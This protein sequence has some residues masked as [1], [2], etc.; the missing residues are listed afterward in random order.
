MRPQATDA[1]ADFDGFGGEAAP[2]I[3]QAD[4]QRTSGHQPEPRAEAQIEAPAQPEPAPAAADEEPRRRQGRTTPFDGS[5]K[6]EL[7]VEQPE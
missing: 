1:V 5:G 2:S 6:G 4:T 7:P 3:A